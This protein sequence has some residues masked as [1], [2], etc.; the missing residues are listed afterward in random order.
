MLGSFAE[1]ARPDQSHQRDTL[2][3]FNR[4][5]VGT[6]IYL[7]F[8]ALVVLSLGIAIVG[9]QQISGT[10]VDS[11]SRLASSNQRALSTTR[12]LAAIRRAETRYLFEASDGSIK[13]A[14][15]NA[16]RANAQLAE[17]VRAAVSS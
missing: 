2:M 13:D 6:R 7:G 4:S 10:D 15:D 1:H 17:S 11:M 9:I 3:G 14:R 12:N 5:K 16:E 8:G